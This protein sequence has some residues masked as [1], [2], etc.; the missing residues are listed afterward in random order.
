MAQVQRRSRLSIWKD[1][2]FALFIRDLQSRFNDKFGISWAIIQPVTFIFILAFI[3]GLMNGGETHTMP[4]FVFMMYGIVSLQFFI[5]TLSA[6]S[7]ALKK[8][9]PLF[10]FRQVVPISS[11][12]ATALFEYI[13]KL[14]VII[15]LVIIMWFLGIELVLKD[16]L[17]VIINFTLLW[18]LALS[19]GIIFA[20]STSFFPEVDKFREMAQRPMLFISAVFFSL[21]DVPQEYWVYLDWNPLLHAIELSRQAAYPSFG[22]V[23]VSQS[24]LYECTIVIF[25]LSLIIYKRYWKQAISV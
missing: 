22:A 23:G 11:F 25:F 13:V 12:I 5:T 17:M 8:D 14:V 18:L 20:I 21:Q 1:V 2:I 15:V 10:A 7:K 19:I 3:R 24:Y 16:P 6:S 4:T 9:K